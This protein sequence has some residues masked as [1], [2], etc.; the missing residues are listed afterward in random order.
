MAGYAGPVSGRLRLTLVAILAL[1]VV[2][3]S[4]CEKDTDEANAYVDAVNRAQNDFSSTFDGL[5]SQITATS[6]PRQD[7]RTL[8][9]FQGAIDEVVAEM[10]A[11]EV[12]PEVASLH[13]RLVGEISRY[14][15]ELDKARKALRSTNSREIVAAQRELVSAVTSVSTKINRTIDAINRALRE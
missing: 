15:E 9:R 4:G 3:V 5:S 1:G 8:Q 14:G 10:S 7:R 11:I 2:A 6:T 12:P 13:R